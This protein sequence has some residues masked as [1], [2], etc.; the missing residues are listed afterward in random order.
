MTATNVAFPRVG[1]IGMGQIGGSIAKAVLAAGQSRVLGFDI[2]PDTCAAARADGVDVRASAA[3]LT[4]DSDLIVLAVPLDCYELLTP[5]I[6]QA[7]AASP[8]PAPRVLIDVGSG[9]LPLR[10]ALAGPQACL[11]VVGTHPMAG[12]QHASYAAADARLLQGCNWVVLHRNDGSASADTEL[13][14]LR[15]LLCLGARTALLDPDAHDRAVAR[16][17]HLPHMLAMALAKTALGGTDAALH[18]SLA[19]GS[20]RDGSRVADT[21]AALTAAMCFGN[22]VAL[23]AAMADCIALLSA[24]RQHLKQTPEAVQADFSGARSLKQTLRTS[25]EQQTRRSLCAVSAAALHPLLLAACQD[26][27]RILDLQ[28]T[29]FAD[30]IRWISTLESPAGPIA[31]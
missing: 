13:A 27:S 7:A 6:A 3:E 21:N 12:T 26:G 10:R 29:I 15:W 5:A 25:F 11:E 4:R 17:S 16:I 23:D 20:F 24:A 30:G 18:Q 9:S 22:A 31:P 2:D 8:A 14:V 1:I 19:A 28:P